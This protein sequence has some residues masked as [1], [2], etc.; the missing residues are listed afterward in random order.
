MNNFSHLKIN[1]WKWKTKS[2]TAKKYSVQE[3]EELI[4]GTFERFKWDLNEILPY[5]SD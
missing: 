5:I 1:L 4:T 2:V 3:T